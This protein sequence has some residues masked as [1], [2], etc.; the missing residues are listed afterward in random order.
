MHL[1][2]AW[3]AD[4]TRILYVEDAVTR[5]VAWPS[6]RVEATIRH[7]DQYPL[8]E[9]LALSPDGTQ[10][11]VNSNESLTLYRGDGSRAWTHAGTAERF[12]GRAAWRDGGRLTVFQR[13]DLSCRTCGMSPATW[14]LRYVDAATGTPAAGPEYPVLRSVLDVRILAWRGDAAYAVVTYS[15]GGTDEPGRVELVRLRPGAPAPEPVLTAPAGVQA[16]TVAADHLDS[17]RPTR[18]PE[19]GFNGQ[20][21]AGQVV[22]GAMCFAPFVGLIVLFVV[23]GRRIRAR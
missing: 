17:R 22:T 7:P 20:E 23:L 19:Y 10:L 18:E 12:G 16:M 9:D 21:V 11:L 3:S 5:V 2:G 14:R 8:D 6:G 15:H 4:G 13:T 1:P